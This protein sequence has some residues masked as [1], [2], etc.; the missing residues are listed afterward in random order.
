MNLLSDVL[1]YIRRIIKSPSNSSI[2]DDLLIDYVNRF[3][4]SDIDARMQ[5][6]DF[7]TKYQ[8]ETI[9]GV[10]DY[11]M[12]L[13]APQTEPGAQVISPFPVYQGFM[14]PAYANGV[15]MPFYTQRELF[16]RT[17]PNYLEWNDQVA[18]GDG[19]TTTF[20]FS[21]PS[22]SQAPAPSVGPLTIGIIPGHIDMTGI[23]AS[24]GTQDPIF[25][26]TFL[27]EPVPNV[28]LAFQ[29]TIPSTSVKSGVYITYIDQNGGN[30]VVADSGQFLD[31]P[32][33]HTLTDGN[34][35]GLLMLPGQAPNG[36]AALPGGYSL[37]V[38]T[39]NYN[40]GTVNVTFPTAPL[41]GSSIN[42]NCAYYQPGLPRQILFYN[43]T[44]SIR[45]PPDT[46]YLIELDAYLTPAAMLSSGTSVPFAYMAEYIARGAA[47]KILSD[48]GDWEQFTS[49]EPLFIEQERLVWKR[50]QRIFTA[51]RTS[52]I[53]SNGEGQGNVGFNNSGQGGF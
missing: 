25:T 47:R 10:C 23:I 14:A 1:T 16:F 12:P 50:S 20:T 28:P 18:I 49:Y 5:L 9:P 51:T 45:P 35:Y 34:L 11:N 17:Y 46:Q 19:V 53:F 30:V 32:V 3:W 42:A 48:T 22:F 52:T 31:R 6:F 13:Y 21:L 37:T 15:Q 33:T 43:N 8:F 38:N 27:T 29:A 24:G 39:V 2:T 26:T 41:A 7:K 44:L 4:I 40:T 36:D